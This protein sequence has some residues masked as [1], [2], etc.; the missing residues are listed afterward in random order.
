MFPLTAGSHWAGTRGTQARAAPSGGPPSALMSL[1]LLLPSGPPSGPGPVLSQEFASMR[2]W[3]G[4]GWKGLLTAQPGAWDAGNRRPGAEGWGKTS[5]VG[6]WRRGDQG[7]RP[8][9]DQ[10]PGCSVREASR[11]SWGRSGSPGGGSGGEPE[12]ERVS[13]AS[14]RAEG[15]VVRRDQDAGGGAPREGGRGAERSTWLGFGWNSDRRW[16]AAQIRG[17]GLAVFP[18][19]SRER[20]PSQGSVLRA[21][22]WV[23]IR[24]A[25]ILALHSS[26]IKG[27]VCSHAVCR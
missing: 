5:G 12:K 8:G 2:G 9:A 18:S 19:D 26:L 10:V 21:A 15:Q 6:R 3:A 24:P 13:L 25:E 22:S 7:P 4:W 27:S 17:A 20:P 11:F 1:V 23:R 14:P 16:A